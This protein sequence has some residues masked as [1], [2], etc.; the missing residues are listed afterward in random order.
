MEDLMFTV[1]INDVAKRLGLVPEFVK[2]EEDALARAAEHPLL[3]IVDLNSRT[4]NAVDLI[5]K[6]KNGNGK[7]PTVIGFVSHVQADLKMQAQE[8]GCDLV[9]ARSAFSQNLPT[10]LKRHAGIM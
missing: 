1:K 4:V 7:G 10:L 2:T 8:A 3:V 5:A 6:L 9:M